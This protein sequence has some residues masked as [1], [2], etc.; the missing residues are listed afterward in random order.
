M[1]GQPPGQGGQGQGAGQ[2]GADEDPMVKMMQSMMGM[3]GGQGGPGGGGA[4]M[5]GMEGMP[6]ML[7]A[8]M[9]GPQAQQQPATSSA[10]LW[11][12]THAIFA[13]TLAGYIALTSTFNGTQLA[14]LKT[15][16]PTTG[17]DT[18]PGIGPRLFWIF[19]TS[20]LLLQSTR[21]FMEKGQL[22][23]GGWLAMIANS[24]FVPEPWAGYVR[25][26]GSYIRIWTTVVSDAMVVVFVLGCLAW[27]KGG[28]GAKV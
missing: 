1:R 26:V 13:L 20:E 7:S 9:G 10:Y 5:E 2:D 24:G 6:Q 22:Q 12:I 15:I 3:M 11:R 28:V 23:G 4:G 17:L 19:V 21:W 27:W 25:T 18:D 16:D 8:M 14:R